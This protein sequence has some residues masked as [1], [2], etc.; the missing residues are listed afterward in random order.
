MC[1]QAWQFGTALLFGVFFLGRATSPTV[2]FPQLPVILY[3][4]LR[5]HGL[6]PVQF[7]VVF[8]DRVSLCSPACS[9]TC[10]VDQALLELMRS[11]SL[12]FLVL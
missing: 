9:G 12:F 2:S 5:P 11:A 7:V 4:G 1:F 8:Q 3:L 10:S 6:L